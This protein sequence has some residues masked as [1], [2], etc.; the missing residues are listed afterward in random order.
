MAEH[1]VFEGVACLEKSV[2]YPEV[3]EEVLEL[4]FPEVLD[5]A[6]SFDE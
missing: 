6:H 3:A 4:L 5:Y 2:A 1:A